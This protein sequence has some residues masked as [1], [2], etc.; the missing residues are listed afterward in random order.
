MRSVQQAAVWAHQ[1][2]PL[3]VRSDVPTYSIGPA[4]Q[5]LMALAGVSRPRVFVSDRL[6]EALTDEELRVALAHE[7]SH[8]DSLDNAKRLLIRLLPDALGGTSIAAAIEQRW[9]LEAE[10]VA[11]RAATGDDAA[12]RCALA[13]AIVKVAGM[14]T[15]PAPALDPV[16]TLVG[17]GDLARRVESLLADA[18]PRRS[19]R[20]ARWTMILALAGA[21]AAYAPLLRAVH[22]VSE[23]LVNSLP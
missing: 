12:A 3:A 17:G 7:A 18:P 6:V 2:V 9:A 10:R 8:A 23:V 4:I 16:S 14:M 22:Q 5:P 19:A 13:S 11:D 1:G 21:A 15:P 20:P